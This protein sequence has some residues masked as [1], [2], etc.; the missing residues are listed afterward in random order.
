MGIDWLAHLRDPGVLQSAVEQ[1]E[2][3]SG[4]R[5]LP[6]NDE[7]IEFQELV[8]PT[9]G[10]DDV[11][12]FRLLIVRYPIEDVIVDDVPNP[13]IFYD[14]NVFDW[15]GMNRARRITHYQAIRYWSD[16][17]GQHRQPEDQRPGR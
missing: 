8:F 9:P 14:F 3:W 1:K 6:I 5:S 2:C 13:Y 4:I 12:S 11:F 15:E 10:R 7:Q 16:P 17:T